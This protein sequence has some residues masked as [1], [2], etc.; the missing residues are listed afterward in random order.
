M[1]NISVYGYDPDIACAADTASLPA[2]CASPSLEPALEPKDAARPS[3]LPPRNG[4]CPLLNL[5]L[6]LRQQIFRRV[7]PYVTQA[8]RRGIC[9]WNRRRLAILR[10]NRQIHD[11]AIDILYRENS[12]S[13]QLPSKGMN[14][15]YTWHV[16]STGLTTSS[17]IS[18]HQSVCLHLASRI[19]Q[20]DIEIWSIDD[21]E[22]MVH[23][24][25]SNIAGLAILRQQHVKEL[26]ND[27]RRNEELKRRITI[28]YFGH[29]TGTGQEKW[30][31]FI[32]QP[33][34]QLVADGLA[35]IKYQNHTEHRI[36]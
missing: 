10:T 22:G 3:D 30:R 4:S 34:V 5:P 15:H 14:F 20:W 27:L 19:R 21:Y 26:S 6:E 11:E 7:L 1:S 17:N 32:V 2:S 12:F 9:V 24:E 13:L 36:T 25:T 16:P 31:R 28:Y 29:D 35:D 8:F 23:Y 18:W 33:L